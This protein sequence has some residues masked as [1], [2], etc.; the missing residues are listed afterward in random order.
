MDLRTVLFDR[1]RLLGIFV[2]LSAEL[3]RCEAARVDHSY[4]VKHGCITQG[5]DED[6]IGSKPMTVAEYR[7]STTPAPLYS[8]VAGSVFCEPAEALELW[9]LQYVFFYALYVSPTV[10]AAVKAASPSVVGDRYLRVF[11]SYYERHLSGATI[12]AHERGRGDSVCMVPQSALHF[13][14]YEMLRVF[15]LY[16]QKEFLPCAGV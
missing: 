5:P 2:T 8:A 15:S 6:A 14:T 1:D 11:S 4:Y 10:R 13:T 9:E 12:L 16:N 7:R 3:Q